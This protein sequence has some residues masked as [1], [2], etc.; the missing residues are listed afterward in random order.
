[1]AAASPGE[2]ARYSPSSQ[3]GREIDRYTSSK[4]KT[5]VVKTLVVKVLTK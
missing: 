5:L 3:A 2:T 1:M 4:D